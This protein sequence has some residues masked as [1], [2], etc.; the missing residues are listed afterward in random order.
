MNRM[1]EEERV[2]KNY[3]RD[4]EVTERN[5]AILSFARDVIFPRSS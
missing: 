1:T 3:G 2:C 5:R 4:I